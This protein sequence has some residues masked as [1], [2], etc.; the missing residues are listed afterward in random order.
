MALLLM[1]TSQLPGAGAN[2]KAFLGVQSTFPRNQLVFG[3]CYNFSDSDC[4]NGYEVLSSSLQCY[5][6]GDNRRS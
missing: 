2:W 4:C 3:L 1:S 5:A 6:L